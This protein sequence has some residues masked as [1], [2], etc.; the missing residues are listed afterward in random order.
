MMNIKENENITSEILEEPGSPYN[1]FK[2]FTTL[3]TWKNCRNTKLFFY[4]EII[5]K[6]P[7]E[8]R[9]NLNTQ[10]RKAA[11]SITANIAE[12]YGR[13]HYQEGIKF[14]RISRASLNELKDHLISSSD[15]KY[16]SEELLLK[17]TSLIEDAKRTLN[18]YIRYVNTQKKIYDEI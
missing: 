9:F 2:D 4:G 8:E 15:L 13:F 18:G 6:L 17:G 10:I 3:D 11:I 12:G 1:S 16:I 5:P 14:Y 7:E